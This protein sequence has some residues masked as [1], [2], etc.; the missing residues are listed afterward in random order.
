MNQLDIQATSQALDNVPRSQLQQIAAAAISKASKVKEGLKK[1]RAIAEAQVMELAKVGT[2]VGA[3]GAMGYVEGIKPEWE[4]LDTA[5][6]IPTM[7]VAGGAA[8]VGGMFL[9]GTAG[10]LAKSAGVGLLAASAYKFG[11][12][13]GEG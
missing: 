1:A 13:K 6:N 10:D 12:S 5:G 8:V 7:A 11:R 2:A 3:A 4:Y 9:G